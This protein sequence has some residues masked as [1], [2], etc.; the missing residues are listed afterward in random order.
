[1]RHIDRANLLTR[2]EAWGNGNELWKNPMLRAD[3]K[4]YFH[5]KCW[6]TE[7]S[8]A[9]S[10]LHIDHFRPKAALQKFKHYRVNTRLLGS[11]YTWLDND[12]NNYRV[13]CAYANR[14]TGI[15]GKQSYFPLRSG[16]P[17][18]TCEGSENELPMLLDP[19]D[20]RD[21]QLLTYCGK[22]IS[23][24]SNARHDQERVRISKTLYN[25][26]DPGITRARSSVWQSVSQKLKAYETGQMARQECIRQL[27]DDVKREAPYSACAIACVQSR[28][29]DEIKNALNLVL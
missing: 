14:H 5:N 26:K 6:Y 2:R 22:R 23:C 17:Y 21:V 12:V 20:A 3:F 18:L 4:E 24:T 1:M 29:P 8:L 25:M 9:G 11:G 7:A 19:C 10:D 13:C 28:A 16:S 15:G 27:K